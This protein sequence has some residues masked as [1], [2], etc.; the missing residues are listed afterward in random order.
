MCMCVYLQADEKAWLEA[1]AQE[2]LDAA[3]AA[4]D[5]LREANA[6]KIEAVE[7]AVAAWD[8][9]AVRKN[10]SDLI[11]LIVDCMTPQ[12]WLPL[13]LFLVAHRPPCTPDWQVV[14]LLRHSIFK[15]VR[16]RS[17]VLSSQAVC[18]GG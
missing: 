14:L 11:S 17:G 8:A 4:Y 15:V 3:K 13:P 18:A 12:C 10:V 2:K 16:T 7:A 5:A 9:A 1:E 6:A